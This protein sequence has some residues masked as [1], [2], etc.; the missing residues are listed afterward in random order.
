MKKQKKKPFK[1]LLKHIDPT[2]KKQWLQSII[3]YM[4]DFNF[5]FIFYIY[6]IIYYIHIQVHIYEFF[7]L[8]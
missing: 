8:P 5:V 1:L 7:K 3:K 4:F 2:E 6:Y